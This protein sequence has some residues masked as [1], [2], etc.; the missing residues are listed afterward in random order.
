MACDTAVTVSSP[1]FPSDLPPT[2]PSGSIRVRSVS[3]SLFCPIGLAVHLAPINTT[4]AKLLELYNKPS[5]LASAPT[6]FFGSISAILSALPF[7]TAFR[8]SLTSTTKTLLG[9]D[10]D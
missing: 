9:F 7:L 3:G 1:S 6:L 8:I 5:W 2:P 4:L 10:Q